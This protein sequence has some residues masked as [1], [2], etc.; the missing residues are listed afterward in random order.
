MPYSSRIKKFA[1]P[2][3]CSLAAWI[4]LVPACL[5]AAEA[6]DLAKQLAKKFS[7][8]QRQIATE[9]AKAEKTWLETRDLL[10][11][12]KTAAPSHDKLP[13]FQK[14]LDD[15]AGKLEKRLGRSI[16]GTAAKP[17]KEP[18]PQPNTAPPSDLPSSVT[19]RLDKMNTA[20]NAVETS[21]AK[22]QLQTA[23][24][25]LT[26]A[27]KL[28]DEIQ[29]RYSKNIPADNAT[30]KTAV[31]RL[32]T[33]SAAYNQAE[34]EEA[35]AAAARAEIEAKQKAQSQE[36][37]AKLS[38]FFDYKS[39][40]Y[41][42]MGASFNSATEEEQQKCRQAY[43]Q[44]NDLMAEYNKTEFPHGK[45]QELIYLEQRLTGYLIIY[46]EGETRA[47][48]D[49]ACAPWVQSL[50]QFVEVGAGSPKYLIASATLGEDEINR[51]AAL[52]EEAQAL[53]A[54]YQKAEFP[55]GKSQE[56]LDLEAG[57]QQRLAEMPEALR[58]SR[59][60]VAGDLQKE[61]DRIQQ[62]LDQDTGWQNDTAK[63]PNLVMERDLQPLREALQKY[64]G[65]VKPDDA[66]LAA[67]TEK[68]AK[69]EKTDLANRTVRAQRTYMAPDNYDQDDADTLR[70]KA[71]KIVKEKIPAAKILRT[72]L[73]A[74]DWQ[75]ENVIEW[76]DSTH[77]AL[78]NRITRFMTAQLAAQA[79]DGKVYLHAV[80]LASDRQSDGAW[81]PLYG[82]IMWSDWMAEENV[83]A[84]SP[85]P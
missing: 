74:E 28:M 51:R 35:A 78:R 81:G 16:G 14:S 13:A 54:D 17:E 71:Q 83:E 64:A 8:I 67:L 9:P 20:L 48:Q 26:E 24:R 85:L 79:D 19:T 1:F 73:P 37:I 47:Q 5:F 45:T 43:A 27:T 22:N 66:K 36:W 53:W 65:T 25:R 57:M 58:L 55:L 2:L 76:T 44:A 60:L 30:M 75:Q 49:Q 6:D 56:L 42:L 82:H 39:D 63:M 38:P 33:V 41:L 11:K 34:A 68:L 72:T 59:S 62:Y 50:R 4:F 18:A 15:L 52:L 32:K 12:L 84:E 21:L 7:D 10:E 80:H 40:Q 3:A 46:N 61:L 77:S 69:I 23:K 31:E 29:Q 70:E